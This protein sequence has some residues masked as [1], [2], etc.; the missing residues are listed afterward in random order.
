MQGAVIVPRI[1]MV[2]SK[3]TRVGIAFD[4]DQGHCRGDEDTNSCVE[5]FTMSLAAHPGFPLIAGK[6]PARLME[7]LPAPQALAERQFPRVAIKVDGRILLIRLGDVVSVEAEG[8]YVLLRI[9]SR[10]YLLREP[11]S[12]VEKKLEPYGFVRIHRSVLVN[13]SFVEEIRPRSTGECGL[14]LRGGKEY[15]VTRTYKRNLKSI[16]K[17][18]IGSAAFPVD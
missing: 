6:K 5:A 18:W 8:N 12:L 1:I 13:T 16:A 10:S 2:M 9:E 11:L 15:T 17:F 4:C 14:H 7:Y 3:S